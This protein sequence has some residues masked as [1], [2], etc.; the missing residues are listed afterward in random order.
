MLFQNHRAIYRRIALIL[1]LVLLAHL[2]TPPVMA[3]EDSTGAKVHVVSWGETLFTIARQYGVTVGEIVEANQLDEADQ[4]Y[5]GQRLIIPGTGSTL[6]RA[7]E[8]QSHIVQDGET[9]YRIALQYGVTVGDLLAANGLDDADQIYTGQELIIPG[10]EAPEKPGDTESPDLPGEETGGV[11]VVQPGETLYAIG[12]LYDVSPS[13]LAS[14][15]NLLNPAQI[16]TGQQLVIPGAATASSPGYTPKET[17]ITY[18]VE[19]GDTLQG[20]ATRHGVSPWVLVQI[21]DISNPSLLY[22]G[23]VL[24][25]PQNSALSAASPASPQ[26]PTDK[27][28]VVDVSD[29][30]TYVY[31]NG[32]LLWT[33]V[34]STGIPGADTFRGEFKIQNKIPMAYAST[35]NLQMPYWLGF[36]WAGPLQNGFH[37]LPILPNGVRL[38]E[39]LL[40]TPASYGCVI[41]STQDAQ[42]LYEWAEVGTPVTVRD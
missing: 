37:A 24:S 36:Y 39:G 40:G 4:I 41:L 15:N 16:Y 38:W 22:P 17:S 11:H 35:W 30:R 12:R 3:Q 2:F 19:V 18:I 10:G 29:Q 1:W 28:I 6:P 13:V 34:S 20:I 8:S 25:I 23:Q 42:T 21:N 9:L 26:Q 27:R 33:F 5:A 7:D 14:I 31:Q 32:G